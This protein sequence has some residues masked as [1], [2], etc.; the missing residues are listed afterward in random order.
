[1]DM[2]QV[3]SFS[4]A[5]GYC[6]LVT[7]FVPLP[8]HANQARITTFPLDDAD[9]CLYSSDV[10]SFARQTSLFTGVDSAF[11]FS[12]T[13]DPVTFSGARYIHILASGGYCVVGV[14][15]CPCD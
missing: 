13:Y 2:S 1:M 12:D 4:C 6:T 11:S 3:S 14:L 7:L 15:F 5:L 10:I 9:S 8:G